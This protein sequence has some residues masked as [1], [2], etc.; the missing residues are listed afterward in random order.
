VFHCQLHSSP[1]MLQCT[2][3]SLQKTTWRPGNCL[4][5]PSSNLGLHKPR[6]C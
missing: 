3:G 2:A 4:P 5:P 6:V 1:F